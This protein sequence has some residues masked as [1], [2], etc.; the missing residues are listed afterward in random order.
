VQGD[1]HQI[2]GFLGHLEAGQ[3]FYRLLSASVSRQGQRGGPDATGAIA[4]T[5]NLELLGLP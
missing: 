3:Q 1:Y 5:L 2:L 4:L